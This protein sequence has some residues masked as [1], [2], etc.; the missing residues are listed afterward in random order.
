MQHA[1]AFLAFPALSRSAPA[2]F[3]VLAASRYRASIYTQA[4]PY[5]AV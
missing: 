4:S 3:E 1:A 5:I 2:A